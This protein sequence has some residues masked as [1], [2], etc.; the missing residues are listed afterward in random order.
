[1]AT[2]DDP[3]CVTYGHHALTGLATEAYND[4]I[5]LDA[6]WSI[7][8]GSHHISVSSKKDKKKYRIALPVCLF[9]IYEG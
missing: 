5:I 3:V 8:V 4:V 1:M 2:F 9:L 7:Y 6:C